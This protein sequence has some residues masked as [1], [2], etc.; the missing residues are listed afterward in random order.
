MARGGGERLRPRRPR[1]EVVEQLELPEAASGFQLERTLE[2]LVDRLLVNPRRRGRSFRRLRLFARLA[3]GGGWR[4][5]ATMRQASAD[6]VRVRLALTP[7]LAELPAPVASL[8]LRALALG[9]A[10]G[11]QPALARDEHEHRRERIGEAVRQARAAAGADAVL[12]VLEVD[13]DSRV[14][15]RR[16]TL[17]PYPE[18]D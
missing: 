14:P 1:E 9:P 2:L 4:A 3:A 7:K 5:D 8:G 13:P 16:V 10:G 17:T 12:R 6:R 15:E 18:A 11:E